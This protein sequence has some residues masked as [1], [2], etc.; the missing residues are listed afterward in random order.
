M[1]DVF[2]SMLTTNPNFEITEKSDRFE[3]ANKRNLG[4]A[5]GFDVLRSLL[6]Q[7]TRPDECNSDRETVIVGVLQLFHSTLVSRKHT[8]EMLTLTQVRGDFVEINGECGK[9]DM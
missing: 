1:L 7:Y 4:D 9:A 2:H 5:G 3:L 6:E 8:T